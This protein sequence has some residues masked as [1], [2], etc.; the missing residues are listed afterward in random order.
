MRTLASHPAAVVRYLLRVGP[1]P[2]PSDRSFAPSLLLPHAGA[3]AQTP[4][5]SGG[6]RSS[7]ARGQRKVAREP[8]RYA[9]A[10]CVFPPRDRS[11]AVGSNDTL[12]DSAV[13]RRPSERQLHRGIK[14]TL[15]LPPELESAGDPRRDGDLPACYSENCLRAQWGRNTV[16][17]PTSALEIHP[18]GPVRR[19]FPRWHDAF[20]WQ[21]RL[22]RRGFAPGDP[23]RGEAL[24]MPGRV[25]PP[26]FLLRGRGGSPRLCLVFAALAMPDRGGLPRVC[27]SSV[28]VKSW[29][30]LPGRGDGSSRVSHAKSWRCQAGNG[31]R[32]VSRSLA[33]PV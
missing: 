4:S 3:S 2:G 15:V 12:L 31:S 14:A 10:A 25:L 1:S 7:A 20:G 9:Y 28:S 13:T 29:R 11:P 32:L 21:I 17:G 5:M 16:A 6:D 24:A 26:P 18:T 8:R 22:E 33:G 27:V 23:L 19:C 30:Y